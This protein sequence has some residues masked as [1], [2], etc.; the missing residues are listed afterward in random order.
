MVKF[1]FIA[2][3]FKELIAP[4]VI[5]TITSP[6]LA[7]YTIIVDLPNPGKAI[8]A[9]AFINNYLIILPLGAS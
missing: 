6:F 3:A 7:L 1:L 2:F 8:M 4:E 9:L 5:A